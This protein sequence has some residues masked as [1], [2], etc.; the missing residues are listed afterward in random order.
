[1]ALVLG[2]TGVFV[3][4]RFASELDNAQKRSESLEDLFVRITSE[5][6]PAAK[7]EAVPA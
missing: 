5:T 6:P 2:A 3:Y 4:L 7:R 1:M